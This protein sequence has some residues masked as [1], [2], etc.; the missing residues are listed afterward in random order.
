[1]LHIS[2]SEL[3]DSMYTQ[4]RCHRTE[5]K[6]ER[7]S[8]SRSSVLNRVLMYVD[9]ATQEGVVNMESKAAKWLTVTTL[10]D[11]PLAHY[12]HS[13]QQQT[14]QVTERKARTCNPFSQGNGF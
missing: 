9:T 7:P 12:H 14:L 13:S 11:L 6:S 10:A 3:D 4:G 5:M 8:R 1:M 2:T